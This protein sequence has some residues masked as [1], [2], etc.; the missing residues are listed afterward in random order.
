MNLTVVS[1]SEPSYTHPRTNSRNRP[2]LLCAK[3]C[4]P[5]LEIRPD[6]YFFSSSN[7]FCSIVFTE[8][9]APWFLWRL[10]SSVSRTFLH[11]MPRFSDTRVCARPV[12]HMLSPFSWIRCFHSRSSELQLQL[13][14]PVQFIVFA[15][16][17]EELSQLEPSSSQTSSSTTRSASCRLELTY[18]SS[19]LPKR[20]SEFIPFISHTKLVRTSLRTVGLLKNQSW[21]FSGLQ[22]TD[23]K[24]ASS[25]CIAGMRMRIRKLT[26]H[27]YNES[28]L[29]QA[30]SIT[31]ITQSVSDKASDHT[32]VLC[33]FLS[34]GVKREGRRELRS[35]LT[36]HLDSK[37][38]WA[39]G[40][41]MT[42]NV[43]VHQWLWRRW[44]RNASSCHKF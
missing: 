22:P 15:R 30:F 38:T 11:V 31:M 12:Q 10:I 32:S 44:S 41:M 18:F 8:T 25:F 6:K 21:F 26:A 43:A 5:K 34:A 4:C 20:C 16:I 27:A 33:F 7:V 39:V 2:S 36:E 19:L 40:K 3:R 42:W 13:K 17:S 29:H 35:W 14:H 24:W 23:M 28:M 1:S 9:V 37:M